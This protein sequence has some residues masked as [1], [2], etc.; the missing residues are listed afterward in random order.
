VKKMINVEDFMSLSEEHRERLRDIT[1]FTAQEKFFGVYESGETILYVDGCE[2]LEYM[3]I[4]YKNKTGI[5]TVVCDGEKCKI[6]PCYT[7]G[8]MIE[9]LESNDI[10]YVIEPHCTKSKEIWV[11]HTP[12][13]KKYNT[14]LIPEL[15]DALLEAIKWCLDE[16]LI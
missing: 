2:E 13:G 9:L 11:E 14:G 6:Y 4:D 12:S 3:S 7:I 15:C 5:Y 1:D 16:G 10:T 8:D